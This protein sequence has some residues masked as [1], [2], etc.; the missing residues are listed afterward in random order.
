[1]PYFHETEGIEPET[2]TALLY[3]HPFVNIVARG[4]VPRLFS[5]AAWQNLPRS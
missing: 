1:M 3:G 5:S 4:L 2:E